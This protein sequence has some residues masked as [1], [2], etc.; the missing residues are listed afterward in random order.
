MEAYQSVNSR[1]YCIVGGML[2]IRLCIQINWDYSLAT[3][4]KYGLYVVLIIHWMACAWWYM[5]ELE[6][7][8]YPDMENW[9]L[10]RRDTLIPTFVH[11]CDL[12][13]DVAH[14]AAATIRGVYILRKTT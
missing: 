3:L 1:P 4:C 8:F 7:L 9:L 14:P 6:M 12:Q 2:L 11:T 10:V 5:G 13:I